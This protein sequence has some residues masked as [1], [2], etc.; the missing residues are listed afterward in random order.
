[1]ELNVKIKIIKLKIIIIK[2]QI[3]DVFVYIKFN[4]KCFR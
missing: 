4:L 2:T 3:F 1:M